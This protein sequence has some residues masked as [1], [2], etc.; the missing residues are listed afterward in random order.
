ME[1]SSLLLDVD[2]SPASAGYVDAVS[3]DDVPAAADWQ[4]AVETVERM[5]RCQADLA[6]VVLARESRV[7]G[8]RRFNP[9]SLLRRL[10]DD[11]PDCF[12]FAVARGEKCFL[13][14]SPERWFDFAI[15]SSR[16]PPSPDRL[17]VARPPRKTGIW[18]AHSWP[19][20]RTWPSM[21]SSCGPYAKDWPSFRSS[22][23][24]W[25]P[26][27]DEIAQCAPSR[28]AHSVPGG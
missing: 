26:F 10:S 16:P 8:R 24:D 11:Y 19:A 14:A 18:V 27:V 12:I 25:P 9:V 13:G 17:P 2:E 15:A 21:T 23:R 5:V 20:T 28:D 7:R 4:A 6:K 22:C 3:S 1:C